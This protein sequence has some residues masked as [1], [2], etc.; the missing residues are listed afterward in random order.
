MGL[1]CHQAKVRGEQSSALLDF[2]SVPNR[3]LLFTHVHCTWKLSLQPLPTLLKEWVVA[4]NPHLIYRHESYSHL[5]HSSPHSSAARHTNAR[6]K[7][8]VPSSRREKQTCCT[9]CFLMRRCTT[10]QE[11]C[12][13]LLKDLRLLE[14]QIAYKFISMGFSVQNRG[15]RGRQRAGGGRQSRRRPGKVGRGRGSWGRKEEAG[16]G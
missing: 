12:L 1:T 15:G 11:S 4:S 5:L 7:A 8:P 14:P 10:P 9:L 13:C 3:R 6:E 16:R 2:G